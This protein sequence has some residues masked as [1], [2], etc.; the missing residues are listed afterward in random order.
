MLLIH[1]WQSLALPG[2]WSFEIFGGHGKIKRAQIF[3]PGPQRGF[4]WY[5]CFTDRSVACY[6]HA[7]IA[8]VEELLPL[9]RPDWE[10][11]ATCRDLPFPFW[12]WKPPHVYLD[13][14]RLI[15]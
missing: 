12:S 14:S 15:R 3:F 7:L 10:T 4:R 5:K 13:R 11:S 6:H 2:K 8:Q 1:P 9:L